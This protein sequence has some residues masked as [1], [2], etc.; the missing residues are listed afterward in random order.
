MQA[1]KNAIAAGF[2]GVELHGANGYLIEQFI[3][4][5]TNQRTDA[6]GGSVEKRIRFVVEVANE[7]AAAIGGDKVGIR[8]SPYG[9]A[10]GM[11]AYPEVEQE[12]L[13]LVDQLAAAGLVYIHIADHA[14]QGAPEVPLAFKLALRKVWPRTFIIG[15]SFDLG[16]AQKAIS[17]GPL[18]DSLVG[19][20][21]GFPG[22]PR[23][24]L[25]LA[26]GPGPECSRLHDAVFARRQ[27]L[28]GLSTGGGLRNTSKTGGCHAH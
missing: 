28:H 2:D 5:Q 13:M 10:S 25:P 18:V 1:A 19:V 20:G 9:V 21:Q 24:G 16:L 26:E 11:A 4:P 27:R 23:P 15:G 17:E 12:Y 14:G 22:Q 7:C 3:S 8:L 6:W